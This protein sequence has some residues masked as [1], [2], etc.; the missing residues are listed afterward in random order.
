[1]Q[2]IYL[3]TR[4]LEAESSAV[5]S[6]TSVVLL[7]AGLAFVNRLFGMGQFMTSIYASN[8]AIEQLRKDFFAKL[9]SLSSSFYHAHKAG[10]LIA[11]GTGD[12][13][14]ISEFMT[15]TLM[16]IVV[17]LTAFGYALYRIAGISPYLLLPSLFIAPIVVAASV[18]YRRSMSRAQRRGREQNSRMVAH[19]SEHVRGVRVVQ[20]FSRE[21]RTFDEFSE[22]NR[23]NRDNEIRIARLDAIF[24]PS[25]DFLGILNTAVVVG[26]GAWLLH[27]PWA[28]VWSQRLTPANLAA[29]ILYSNTILWPLR[30]MVEMYSMSM[31]AMAAAERIYEIMDM[32]PAVA[33]PAD[34]APADRLRGE[35]EFRH[36]DF[37]YS[38]ESPWV[39][40][41]F[42][43]RI[44]AGRTVALVGA[45]GAGKT[46]L[47][48]L[49]ARFYDATA[50]EVLIDGRNVRAYRQEDLHRHMAVVPQDG[51]LFSGSILDNIRFRRPD[52]T[53]EQTMALARDLGIGP[54]LERLA[55]GYDTLALEGGASISEGQRQLV[56]IARA[57]A[58]DP[59]ILIL[60]EPTSALDVHTESLLQQ[61]MD[62]LMRGRTSLLIA[63]RLST[64]RSADLIVVLDGGRIV[65]SGSH[66]ELLRREGR[67]AELVRKR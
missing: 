10:W 38:P 63:H 33:D 66:A 9:Q 43:L 52:M 1:M 60:D 51:F 3:A 13:W 47:S 24:M 59:A 44:P 4:L 28:D 39:L 14:Y 54:A 41:D 27:S 30:M 45:T 21:R 53:R 29:Y 17:F 18:A 62:R 15:Y 58:A 20:A 23:I 11:R 56:S 2:I 57:L 55:Q 65:E 67:Y 49:A 50:G 19:M 8:K 32:P 40:R 64:V 16:M 34:P 61:A 12:I 36:V 46:T 22:L 25:M 48:A 35:I 37:R 7:L 42:S 6:A 31:R 5:R 26:F